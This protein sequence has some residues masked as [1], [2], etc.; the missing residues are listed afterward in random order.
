M[1][2]SNGNDWAPKMIIPLKVYPTFPHGKGD[3]YGALHSSFK[4]DTYGA[5]LSLLQARNINQLQA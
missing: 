1:I 2:W 3:N 5:L 4:G